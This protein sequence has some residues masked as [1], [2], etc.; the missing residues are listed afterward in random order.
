MH[1]LACA[2]LQ[3]D[4]LCLPCGLARLAGT[5]EGARLSQRRVP[6][7]EPLY[8]QGSAYGAIYAVRAGSFKSTVHDEDGLE[9]VTGFHVDGDILGLDG[10]AR[11]RHASTAVALEDAEVLV[12]PSCDAGLDPLLP[13]LMSREL[14]RQRE[15]LQLLMGRSAEA[16]VATFVQDITQRMHAR[17]YSPREFHLRLSR[18][19]I[20]SYL[21]LKLET[22]SRVFGRLQR[23]RVLRAE[24][25][26]VRVLDPAALAAAC[27]ASA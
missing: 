5:P 19:E 23:Q 10:M 1:D 12:L 15:R 16:R 8:R 14:V 9:Q 21:G 6:R 27:G 24:G 17:G 18:G 2:S 13:R 3:G 26:H 4:D 25:R 22:V 11:L 7:G 20:G